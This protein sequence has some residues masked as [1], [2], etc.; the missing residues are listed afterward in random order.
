MHGSMGNLFHMLGE[1]EVDMIA[2]FQTGIALGIQNISLMLD[3]SGEISYWASPVYVIFLVMKLFGLVA[4]IGFMCL[5]PL[6]LCK[7]AHT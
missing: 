1:V 7:G 5:Y 6:A 3:I 2:N 4:I